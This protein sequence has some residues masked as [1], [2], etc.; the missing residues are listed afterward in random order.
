MYCV[1]A[2]GLCKAVYEL[3]AGQMA[4]MPALFV[5]SFPPPHAF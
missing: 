2:N 3:Q 4:A 5:F 1:G